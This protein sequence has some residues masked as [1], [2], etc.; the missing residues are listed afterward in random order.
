[1]DGFVDLGKKKILVL[2]D[3][4]NI[5]ATLQ[6][7]LE[8]KEYSVVAFESP[9]IALNRLKVEPFD[10]VLSDLKMPEMDGL[11]F[12]QEVKK[13]CPSLPV[14]LVTVLAD[15]DRAVRA[16]QSG[17]FDYVTKPFD[18]KKIYTV[19]EQALMMEQP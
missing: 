5:A 15:V 18:I 3:D 6:E 10:L 1:M 16:I 19:V 8:E 11:E 12:L 13:L 9:F 17:A 2:D 4:P 7:I 14:I